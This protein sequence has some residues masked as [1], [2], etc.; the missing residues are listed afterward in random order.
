MSLTVLA[1]AA[2]GLI[3]SAAGIV[4]MVYTA[5]IPFVNIITSAVGWTMIVI[6]SM[7]TLYGMMPQFAKW[8][9]FGASALVY[10]IGIIYII[11]KEWAGVEA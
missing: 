8:I 1:Y 2:V 11:R 6:G 7:I 4:L 10:I 9:F 5:R 3:F